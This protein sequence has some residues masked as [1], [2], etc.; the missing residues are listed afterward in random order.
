MFKSNTD[1]EHK[2]NKKTKKRV[3][4]SLILKGN[5]KNTLQKDEY[6][7]ENDPISVSNISY[8]SI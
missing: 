4:N 8:I 1:I 7:E 6:L 3:I 5:A 2:K